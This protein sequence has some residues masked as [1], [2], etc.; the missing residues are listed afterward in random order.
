MNILGKSKREKCS[1][2]GRVSQKQGTCV[3]RCLVL[4]RLASGTKSLPLPGLNQTPRGVGRLISLSVWQIAAERFCKKRE[5]LL[6]K[7]KKAMYNTIVGTR[8]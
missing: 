8:L 4:F 3:R 5:L 2:I 1:Q 7:V 6:E